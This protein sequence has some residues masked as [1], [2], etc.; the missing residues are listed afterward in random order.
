[1]CAVTAGGANRVVLI[2]GAGGGLGLATAR[3]YAH[4]GMDAALLDVDREAVEKAAAEISAEG[5]RARAWEADVSDEAAVKAAVTQ[6]GEH[7]GRLD[8]LVNNAGI[9]QRSAF[10]NTDSAV[11][12]RVMDI[13]FFGALYATQAALPWLEQ[14]RGRIVV[15]SS[16][17]GFAPLLGRTAYA[18]SKHALHGL[19]ETLRTELRADGVG[20]TMICP[21]FVATNIN[22][23]AL[24]GD[25]SRT[26]HPQSTVG[27]VET[28][29]QAADLIFR[30]EQRGRRLLIIGRVGLL[31]RLLTRAAPGVYD[32][33]MARA[34][35]RELSRGG[36]DARGE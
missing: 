20:V 24:D 6:A 12:R 36:Q 30:A 4:S 33:I 34:V 19:F 31:T 13:N 25:G 28:A 2:T 27:R 29:E 16:V 26:R 11:Y 1:V 35:A 23:N 17:A 3:R 7:F 22:V 8:V 15:I 18:A 5:V 9:S 21:S 32:R 10:R 14:S